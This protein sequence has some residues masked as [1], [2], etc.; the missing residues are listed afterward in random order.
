MSQIWVAERRPVDVSVESSETPSLTTSN[1][2]ITGMMRV[3]SADA[4]DG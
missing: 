4:C 3:M 2:R 1:D